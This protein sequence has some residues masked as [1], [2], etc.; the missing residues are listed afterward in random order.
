MAFQQHP[1]SSSQ[2]P[3]D[4]SQPLVTTGH[5]WAPLGTTGHI[6]THFKDFEVMEKQ[7][8]ER[9]NLLLLLSLQLLSQLG[10]HD[11]LLFLPLCHIR[12][13]MRSKRDKNKL[14]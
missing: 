1:N 11:P 4:P 9:P 7:S 14:Q 6:P 12:H 13:M 3:T 5:H 8:P 2:Q 10:L